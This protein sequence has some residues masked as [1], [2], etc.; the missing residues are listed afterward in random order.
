MHT[1]RGFVYL[2]GLAL[3]VLVPQGLWADPPQTLTPQEL[4]ALLEKAET[5]EDH[6]KLAAHYSGDAERFAR[7]AERHEALATR[8]R[9]LAAYRGMAKHCDYLARSLRDAAKA[10]QQLAQSHKEMAEKLQR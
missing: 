1:L 2:V 3:I 5:A 7:D 8:Y 6:L 4:D 10:S 9:K